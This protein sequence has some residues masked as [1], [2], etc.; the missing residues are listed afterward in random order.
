MEILMSYLRAGAEEN[1]ENLSHIGRCYILDAYRERS[2]C[3]SNAIVL[4]QVIPSA[5]S[6]RGNSDCCSN[7]YVYCIT[8]TVTDTPTAL[9]LQ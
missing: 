6:V 7:R 4:Y 3:K 8:T 5:Q 2:E 9:L 1:H